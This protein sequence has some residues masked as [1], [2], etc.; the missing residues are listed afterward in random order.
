ML[1]E[2][3]ICP[4]CNWPLVKAKEGQEIKAHELLPGWYCPKCERSQQKKAS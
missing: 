1:T 4:H 3:P 2:R